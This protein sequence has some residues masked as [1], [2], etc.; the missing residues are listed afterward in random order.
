MEKRSK[1]EQKILSS[2]KEIESSDLAAHRPRQ[3]RHLIMPT[4]WF[5]VGSKN[6]SASTKLSLGDSPPNIMSSEA[7]LVG[8]QKETRA[9]FTF[10]ELTKLISSRWREVC[11][12]DP[13]TKEFCNK[14]ASKEAARYKAELEE[15]RHKYGA[16]AAKGKKRK[17]RKS[18]LPEPQKKTKQVKEEEEGEICM[19]NNFVPV[20]GNLKEE[21][22]PSP[23]SVLEDGTP[24]IIV[25]MYARQREL[26]AQ[27]EQR[28]R[29]LASL[30]LSSSF[31]VNTFQGIPK[32]FSQ[33]QTFQG[34]IITPNPPSAD[35][36][37]QGRQIL[38]NGYDSPQRL[39]G[40]RRSTG[41]SFVRQNSA[42]DSKYDFLN[43]ADGVID[44]DKVEE[45]L[46]DFECKVFQQMFKNS[47]YEDP[48]T[49]GVGMCI[50]RNL[51]LTKFHRRCVEKSRSRCSPSEVS[52]FDLANVTSNA[53]TAAPT[54]KKL[55]SLQSNDW[56]LFTKHVEIGR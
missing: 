6:K 52:Q 11:K 53:T 41:Q 49:S 24:D 42:F 16:E 25:K 22:R 38:Q 55:R 10:L 17:P 48:S 46:R 40:M 39:G 32:D 45:Y 19:L 54:L 33:A 5:I 51:Y 30:P 56:A 15:Y 27:L 35:R 47:T 18:L 43:S 23:V 3:Y 9:K 13:V 1:A 21:A 26:Q 37:A 12:N 50:D 44:D 20:E 8:K 28:Q 2:G 34:A 14:I 7:A 31:T 29:R 4:D 36:Y